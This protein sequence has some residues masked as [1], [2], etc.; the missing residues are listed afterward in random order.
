MHGVQTSSVQSWSGQPQQGVQSRS[1]NA[2]PQK[3]AGIPFVCD[4]NRRQCSG[5]NILGC[6]LHRLDIGQLHGAFQ[7]AC[8]A[9]PQRGQAGGTA[10]IFNMM[11]HNSEDGPYSAAM[12]SSYFLTLTTGQGMLYIGR[13]YEE[14]M[15]AAGFPLC[16]DSPP[17]T[18]PRSHRGNQN[19]SE[20]VG[21]Q[22][23]PSQRGP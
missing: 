22:P 4:L 23:L 5:F 11:Q 6:Q 2:T 13:G 3:P 8:D 19:L 16:R 10:I 17:P 12:A 7:I 14:W 18:R 21:T 9:V 20:A 1:E 15:R